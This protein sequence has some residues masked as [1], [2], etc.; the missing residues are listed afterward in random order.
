MVYLERQQII[1]VAPS[2]GIKLSTAKHILKMFRKEG[3]ILR[4]N[5]N[6]MVYD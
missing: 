1:R 5:E 2:L 3:K 6:W 4:K